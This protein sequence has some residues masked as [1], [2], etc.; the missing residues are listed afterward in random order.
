MRG[1][2]LIVFVLLLFVLS[3]ISYA[4]APPPTPD[5]R[6]EGIETLFAPE[7]EEQPVEEPVEEN[8][9]EPEINETVVEP[10]PIVENITEESVSEPPPI[11]EIEEEGS[12]VMLIVGLILLILVV[13]VSGLFAYKKMQRKNSLK[14][15]VQENLKKGYTKQQISYMLY[16]NGYNQKEID[17]V[18]KN[19]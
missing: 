18:M 11:Q 9:S 6:G 14:A 15:Y 12:N 3:F 1:T 7:P 5:E 4:Q 17:K 19:V 16:K 2:R 10:E 8:V 13:I